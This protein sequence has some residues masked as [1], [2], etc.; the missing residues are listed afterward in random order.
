M[1]HDLPL[2][3]P[4]G[5]DWRLWVRRW[6]RMQERYL[7]RRPERFGVMAAVI[8]AT[9]GTSP[10]ILDLGCGPGSLSAR[11]LEALPGARAVGIDYDPA[12]LCLAE[13]RLAVFAGRA[14]VLRVDLRDAAWSDAVEG[15]FNAVV[16]AT[17]LHWLKPEDLAGLYRAVARLLAPGGVFMNADHVAAESPAVQGLWTENRARMR[18]AQAPRDADDWNGFWLEYAKALGADLAALH[19]GIH[20]WEGEGLEDGLPLSW[21]FDALRD[22]GLVSP[23]CFWRLD[24]DAVYCALKP[25]M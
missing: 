5:F 13:K 6:E 21:H 19:G 23:E 1:G 18:E 8:A 3:L 9:Q 11:L 20:G 7:M 10:S 12:M 24:C 16:S 22:A 17:S 25:R 14:R 2:R 4:D 15:P